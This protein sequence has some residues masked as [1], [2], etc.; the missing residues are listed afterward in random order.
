MTKYITITQ[1][2]LQ[3]IEKCKEI[4]Q[5]G[6]IFGYKTTD[7]MSKGAIKQ[8]VETSIEQLGD[9]DVVIINHAHLVDM[10]NFED[11]EKAME[12][13]FCLITEFTVT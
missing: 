2:L 4:G 1:F 10:K 8:M 3:V 5:E 9:L 6:A 12:V 7:M 11:L 13:R